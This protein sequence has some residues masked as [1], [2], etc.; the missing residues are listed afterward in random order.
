MVDSHEKH[1][2]REETKANW[3]KVRVAGL[4]KALRMAFEEV[5]VRA[6]DRYQTMERIY[7]TNQRKL[8]VG[9]RVD[10]LLT[11]ARQALS[12]H[13]QLHAHWH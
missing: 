13:P 11:S 8:Y 5:F 4:G 9:S 1:M 10:E 2:Q 12:T 6:L 3:I 7:S